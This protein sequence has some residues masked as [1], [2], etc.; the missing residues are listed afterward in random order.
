MTAPYPS[1]LVS[2]WAASDGATLEIRPIRGDDEPLE[3][4][5][6]DRLSRDTSYRRLLSGRTPQ[7]DEIARWTHVD[8]DREMAL[9]A[10][11][12]RDESP[13]MCGVTR[14]VREGDDAAAF[15]IV[16]ADDWQ[17][18]GL[19][20]ALLRALVDAARAAGIRTL[21]DITLS[22]NLAMIGLARR[23]GFT[24]AH[25]PGDSTVSVL[26][27]AIDRDDRRRT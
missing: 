23:L 24:I 17:G 22:T 10:V 12:A 19:G 8:Y 3:Q 18:R 14:Y 21:R 4:A 1:H 5:F 6:V 20:T 27:L 16:L 26:E 11:D 15:A 9:V 7:P 2:R 13:R 25:A